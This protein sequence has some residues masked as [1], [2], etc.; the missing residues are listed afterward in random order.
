MQTVNSNNKKYLFAV[1]LIVFVIAV[2]V[3]TVKYYNNQANQAADLGNK[4]ENSGRKE[5]APEDNYADLNNKN[6]RIDKDLEKNS[7]LNNK[8]AEEECIGGLCVGGGPMVMDQDV[9][10]LYDFEEKKFGTDPNNRDTDN[11]GLDDYYEV[12]IYKTDPLNPDTD[13]DGYSDGEEVKAG[14]NPNGEGKIE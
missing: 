7:E 5:F 3:F 12:R 11:D 4:E 10:G 13:G 6:N 1:I 9:D 14:Y 2:S 8:Q